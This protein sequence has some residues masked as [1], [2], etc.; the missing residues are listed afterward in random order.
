M[1]AGHLLK[2]FLFGGAIGAGYVGVKSFSKRKESNDLL[3]PKPQFF[4]DVA[5][6]L[7]SIFVEYLSYYT[8]CPDRWKMMYHKSIQQAIQAL[9]HL[10]CIEVQLAR[11]E[12]TK[13]SMQEKM[14]AEQW[15][16]VTMRLLR[17]VVFY[18][19][20]SDYMVEKLS[21][22]ADQ[23]LTICALHMDNIDKYISDS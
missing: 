10:L 1:N 5:P 6:D 3:D 11:K 23:V 4:K 14:E 16:M 2:G 12:L 9:D 13:P 20:T 18:F 8:I 15:T 17:Q 21:D 22:K 7:I 19:L